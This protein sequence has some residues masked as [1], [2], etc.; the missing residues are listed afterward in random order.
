[1][2]TDRIDLRF[3]GKGFRMLNYYLKVE[4]SGFEDFGFRV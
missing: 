2:V 3:R 4:S 1:M